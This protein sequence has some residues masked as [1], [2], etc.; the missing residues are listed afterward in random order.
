MERGGGETV[1]RS[2]YTFKGEWQTETK[3]EKGKIMRYIAIEREMGGVKGK[4][5]LAERFGL[6]FIH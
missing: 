2:R 3:G 6:I 4:S 5:H 1:G